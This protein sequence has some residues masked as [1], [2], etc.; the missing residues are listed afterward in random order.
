MRSDSSP[1]YKMVISSGLPELVFPP[2]PDVAGALLPAPPSWPQE[3]RRSN[4][5][6]KQSSRLIVLFMFILHFL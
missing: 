6:T 4:A 2:L 3:A 5:I 1:G